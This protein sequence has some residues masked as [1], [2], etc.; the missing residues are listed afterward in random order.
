[1][2]RYVVLISMF[3][4]AGLLLGPALLAGETGGSDLHPG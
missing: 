1:M 3:L 4:S 2:A